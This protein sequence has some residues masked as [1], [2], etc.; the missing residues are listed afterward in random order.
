MTFPRGLVVAEL[1]RYAT[2]SPSLLP[3][4]LP[5]RPRERRLAS[6]AHGLVGSANP[7]RT[8]GNSSPVGS[9]STPVC[10]T[11]TASGRQWLRSSQGHLLKR[12]R[13]QPHEIKTLA[14]T[15]CGGCHCQW[16]QSLSK[17]WRHDGRNAELTWPAVTVAS[18]GHSVAG[19][20]RKAAHDQKRTSVVSTRA[21]KKS[22][23]RVC[24]MTGRTDMAEGGHGERHWERTGQYDSC[25]T[26]L[27]CGF[28]H[29]LPSSSVARRGPGGERPKGCVKK[30][31]KR[32]VA[33]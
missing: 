26:W 31:D 32:A 11:G 14:V 1:V 28:G 13:R 6:R 19:P 5:V 3:R 4:P 18:E 10:Q 20:S 9:P 22:A 16:A 33:C 12:G 27:D 8:A 25:P 24:L 15:H 21:R 23:R 2:Q 29:G 17:D 7:I 30:G